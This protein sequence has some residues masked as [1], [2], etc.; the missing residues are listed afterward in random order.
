MW[1][2]D[3]LGVHPQWH[4]FPGNITFAQ[5]PSTD[6]KTMITLTKTGLLQIGQRTGVASP[7]LWLHMTWASSSSSLFS[8]V[9]TLWLLPCRRGPMP[10][11]PHWKNQET[12]FLAG[13]RFF[14]TPSEIAEGAFPGKFGSPPP[15]IKKMTRLSPQFRSGHPLKPQWE[16][17]PIFFR[18]PPP[19]EGQGRE[20]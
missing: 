13:S 3:P 9:H 11:P 17:L 1:L 18:Y 12:I 19:L 6:P 10:P 16:C 20:V 8:V 15:P 14:R 2:H 4:A 5:R 7:W